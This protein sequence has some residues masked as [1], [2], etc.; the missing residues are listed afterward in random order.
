MV[1]T[2]EH[3]SYLQMSPYIPRIRVL[4]IRYLETNPLSGIIAVCKYLVWGEDVGL[5]S[6]QCK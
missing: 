5:G 1:P 3:R 2:N 4:G 6:P